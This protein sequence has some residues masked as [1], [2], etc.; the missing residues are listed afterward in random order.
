[1]HV[2]KQVMRSV[3]SRV[4]ADALAPCSSCVTAAGS[5]QCFYPAKFKN[6]FNTSSLQALLLLCWM[7]L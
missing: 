5:M 3:S 2:M 7:R 6:A 1:M 4:P